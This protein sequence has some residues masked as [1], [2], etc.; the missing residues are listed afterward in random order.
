MSF[1][2]RSDTHQLP[3]AGA[4][5]L[6]RVCD[7]FEAAWVAGER[8][9]LAEYLGP[10]TGPE[11]AALARE[12]IELDVYYRRLAGEFPQPSDYDGLDPGLDRDWLTRALDAAPRS[13][14]RPTGR[15][16]GPC[17]ASRRRTRHPPPRSEAGQHSALY[18]GH[19]GQQGLE[20]T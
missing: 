6:D 9:A 17:R 1:D 10:F 18:Q 13:H 4:E 3:L 5:H 8:P 7:R 12:L 20:G 16:A 2:S 15:N 14:R 11:R 19:K